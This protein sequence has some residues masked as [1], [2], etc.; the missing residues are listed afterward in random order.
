M[1]PDHLHLLRA[2]GWLMLALILA[3]LALAAA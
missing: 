3:M 1:N 2:L